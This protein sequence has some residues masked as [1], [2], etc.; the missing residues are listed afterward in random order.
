MGLAIMDIRSCPERKNPWAHVRAWKAAFG[1]DPACVLVM[2]LRVG[3]RT[4]VVL[5]ELAEV[6]HGA[7]NILFVT[8]ELS[9]DEIAGLHHAANLYLSLHRAE[10]FGLN[11]FESLLIGRVVVATDWSACAEYGRNFPRYQSISS[12][13]IDYNDWTRHYT[14]QNFKWADADLSEVA[15]KLRAAYVQQ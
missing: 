6:A 15:S 14:N 12:V 4:R 9:E 10:G 5:K 2:K 3:K 1:D 13:L 11:I 7:K 8:E